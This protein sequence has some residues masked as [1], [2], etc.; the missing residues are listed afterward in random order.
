MDLSTM[1]TGNQNSL[2]G[3]TS[4]DVGHI[5]EYTIDTD[6]NGVAQLA[7]NPTNSSIKHEHQIINW[8]VQPAQSECYPG[9]I[10]GAPMHIHEINNNTSL[11][12]SYIN[13]LV[14]KKMK[15]LKQIYGAKGQKKEQLIGQML[16]VA[17]QE[18][19]ISY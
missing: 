16:T 9:C 8:V 6:G 11:A 13:K 1:I 2:S 18:G 17:T 3:M 19:M 5:H 12:L 7:V 4:K 10:E 14:R 15:G